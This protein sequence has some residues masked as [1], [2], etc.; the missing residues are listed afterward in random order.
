MQ[1]CQGAVQGLR[2]RG[3]Q[4]GVGVGDDQLRPGQAALDQAAEEAFPERLRLALADVEADHLPVAALMDGVGEHQCFRHHAAAV[5]DLLDLGIKPQI[6]V[7]ALE[8]PVPERLH[9]LI[10]TLADP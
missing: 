7:A 6:R 9:L 8:R 10:E 3:L 5:T 2:D 1:R 4:A